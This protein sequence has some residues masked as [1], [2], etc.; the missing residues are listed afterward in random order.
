MIDRL[1]A[2]LRDALTCMIVDDEWPA[3]FPRAKALGFGGEDK[4]IEGKPRYED[5]VTYCKHKGHPVSKSAVGRWALGIKVLA[6]MRTKAEVV[7]GVFKD[8]TA[9]DAPKTQ[10]AAAEI[11]T[12][13]L[14]ELGVEENLSPKEIM[15]LA[16]AVKDCTLVSISADKYVRHQ[17]AKKVEKTASSIKDKLNAAGVNK[18][19]QKV[20]DDL[21]LGIA[22]S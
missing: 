21:L 16:R 2:D 19:V 12:A 9:E 8:V 20:I 7:R 4:D 6:Q 17:I 1:P 11:I 10:K 5:L 15:N 3:D 18:K 22:K 14:I 13:R